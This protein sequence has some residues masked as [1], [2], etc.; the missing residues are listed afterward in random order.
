MKKIHGQ[1]KELIAIKD[2]DK[3]CLSTL[4]QNTREQDIKYIMIQNTLDDKIKHLTSMAQAESS[5]IIDQDVSMNVMETSLKEE[6]SSAS[7]QRD[8]ETFGGRRARCWR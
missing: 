4:K 1:F 5:S 7:S 2:I 3:K 6:A 8:N